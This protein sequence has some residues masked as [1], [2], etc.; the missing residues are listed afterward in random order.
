VKVPITANEKIGRGAF[1]DGVET[2]TFEAR[3]E[4]SIFI[5][6]RS[7]MAKFGT[8]ISRLTTHP[9]EG[10]CGRTLARG[11]PGS[12]VGSDISAAAGGSS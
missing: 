5:P 3:D 12:L 6:G 7:S 10:V 1:R 2:Q 9:L 4:L 8:A 11:E